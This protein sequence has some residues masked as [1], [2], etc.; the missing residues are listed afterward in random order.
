MVRALREKEWRPIE[1]VNKRKSVFIENLSEKAHVVVDD[2][3]ATQN[4]RI[5]QEL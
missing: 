1:R 5:P 2:V 4:S 3:M